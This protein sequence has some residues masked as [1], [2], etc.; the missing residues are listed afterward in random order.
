MIK[1]TAPREVKGLAKL[2]LI[3][4]FVNTGIINLTN[5][6]AVWDCDYVK[7]FNTQHLWSSIILLVWG[8]VIFIYEI[9]YKWW[10]QGEKEAPKQPSEGVR[11][12]YVSNSRC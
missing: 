4:F 12:M 11:Y 6:I 10:I 3:L 1:E 9:V 2:L 5:I 8:F 7:D